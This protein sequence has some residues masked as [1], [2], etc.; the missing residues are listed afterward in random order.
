MLL[1]RPPQYLKPGPQTDGGR[2][3]ELKRKLGDTLVKRIRNRSG[4]T[5]TN[6]E[7][8]IAELSRTIEPSKDSAIF[9]SYL[10][11]MAIPLKKSISHFLGVIIF[12]RV[13]SDSF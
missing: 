13:S 8:E 2:C 1:L 7:S 11:V 12:L 9:A 10:K 3:Q 6:I 5:T 4:A